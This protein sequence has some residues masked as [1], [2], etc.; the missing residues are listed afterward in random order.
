MH[1]PLQTVTLIEQQQ[2]LQV[3][4]NNWVLRITGAKKVDRRRRNYLSEGAV[5]FNGKNSKRP[6]RM[7]EGQLP[8]KAES[9]KEP[10]HKKGQNAA[11]TT[12]NRGG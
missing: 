11:K 6:G 1:V 12:K 3:C 4:K 9:I 2:K 7:D 10:C 8:K 5:Q